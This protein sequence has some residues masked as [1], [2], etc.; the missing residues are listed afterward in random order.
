MM[1]NARQLQHYAAILAGSLCKDIEALWMANSSKKFYKWTQ[2][3]PIIFNIPHCELA[4]LFR[5]R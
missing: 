5:P 3:T 4:P 1:Y 2:V